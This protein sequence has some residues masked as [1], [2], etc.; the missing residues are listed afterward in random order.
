MKLQQTPWF[1]RKD[2]GSTEWQFT[3]RLLESALRANHEDELLQNQLPDVASELQA[4]WVGLVRKTPQWELSA[5]FGHINLTEL[6]FNE[7][8][9]ALDGGVAM[10][11]APPDGDEFWPLIGVPFTQPDLS[12]EL[13]LFSG[14]DLQPEQVGSALM[15][16]WGLGS[17]IA[18]VRRYQTSQRRSERL[19]AILKIA[20]QL[21][22]ERETV[23]LLELI[24]NEATRLL[25]ADRASIFIW[26]QD[27]RQVIACPALGVEGGTLRLSDSAGIV[28][29]VIQT[30]TS[31]QVDDAYR[32]A[33]FD[34]KVDVKSGYKTENLLCVPLLNGDGERIGAFEVIN[35][36][37]G[38]FT[39]EDEE[40]LTQ[41]GIQ[42]AT[43]LQSTQD[44]E[45]LVRT[46]KQLTEQVTEGVRIVGESPAITVLKD[47]IQR[48]AATELPVLILGESGTGK[49]VV[50]QSLHYHGPRRD[51]PFVAVNCAALAET[52]LESELFGHEKGAFT[53]AH[54][55]RQGK[56]EL[57]EGGTLFLDEIGDMTLGG[58]AKLLRVLEQKVITRVGGSQTIPINVRVVAA[59]NANLSEAVRTK[60][61]REDLYYR[62]GVVTLDLPPL[63][64]RPEDVLLLAEYFLS[65]FS[66]QAGRKRLKISADARRRLQ[67]HSWPGNIRELRNLMERVAFLAPG[68][69]VE[70]SDLAFIL[71]PDRS[72]MGQE[73][74]PSDGT[75]AD[76]TKH[77]QQRFIRGAV[78]RVQGNMSEAARMLGLHRSNLYRK[79][80]QLEMGEAE[81]AED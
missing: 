55:A 62:L 72:S 61:F 41:L 25:E 3:L 1:D 20:S 5:Q 60:K 17:A 32:D 11:I 8:D 28:G 76:A 63:R 39:E 7:L 24:A 43:A 15:L 4:Q 9:N 68:E 36:L 50:S 58:Q 69:K 27:H 57:A 30:G 73:E 78:K 52:L 54:E 44:R 56:F 75:L 16:G 80:R 18:A 37:A 59:T 65:Q 42:A 46:Q 48:L 10:F 53:D 2:A 45:Q 34:K 23:P 70:V 79:M 64:D 14:R 6:P 33:R 31:I 74:D 51:H 71:S 21:S 66:V 38:A 47:T 29:E 26:D 81:D 35:K 12:G 19:E 67:A 40:S 13:L 77:F 22:H 49:E